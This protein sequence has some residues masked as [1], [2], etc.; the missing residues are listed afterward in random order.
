MT[1]PVNAAG[2]LAL[3]VWDF[4]SD[5]HVYGS[6]TAEQ[7]DAIRAEAFKFSREV[8]SGDEWQ[9]HYG[10]HLAAAVLVWANDPSPESMKA[11]ERC[12]RLFEEKRIS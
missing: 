2:K 6:V 12:S 3:A 1:D 9:V 7:R 11:V 10:R 8:R 5:H 4:L